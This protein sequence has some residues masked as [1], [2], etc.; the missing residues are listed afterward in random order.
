MWEAVS[1]FWAGRLE[2]LFLDSDKVCVKACINYSDLDIKT[3]MLW[4]KPMNNLL[5]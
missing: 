3:L 4:P 2:R 5:G 1:E